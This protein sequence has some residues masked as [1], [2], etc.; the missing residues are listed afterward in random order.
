MT[1]LFDEAFWNDRYRDS[2]SVWS[3][4][5]N[6]V[7]VAEVSDLP[8]GRA[9]DIGSGEGADV[10]W[11][12][13]RGWTV[14]GADISVVALDRARSRSADVAGLITWEHHDFLDW[15]PEASSFDLVSAQFMHLPSEQFD[16]LFRALA[17]AVAPGGTL[18]VVAH[19]PNG[20][21]DPDFFTSAADLAATLDTTHWDVLEAGPR[22]RTGAA[23]V[24]G[25]LVDEVLRMR[26]I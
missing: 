2:D 20:H 9:L 16:R 15:T 21:L 12:A 23:D 11:L 1:A 24:N 18:L 26:R 4:N 6:P 3:G 17:R 25:H 5:P 7:L 22:A 10:M 13:R 14:T 19:Q 8:V